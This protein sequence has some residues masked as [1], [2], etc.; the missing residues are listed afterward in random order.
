MSKII[1]HNF[2]IP[3]LVMKD[4][5]LVEDKPTIITCTFTLLF[6]GMGLFEEIHGS[7]LFTAML[8]LVGGNND[9]ENAKVLYGSNVIKDLAAAS[10]VKIDG[11]RF[12]NNRKTVDEFI[13]GRVYPLVENDTEFVIKLTQMAMECIY[14]KPK[15][16]ATKAGAGTE[17]KPKK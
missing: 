17:A 16:S 4:G 7:P 8:D 10:Y 5:E 11:D 13:N 3:N 1:K 12:H 9:I 14:G 15:P 6:K 2:S